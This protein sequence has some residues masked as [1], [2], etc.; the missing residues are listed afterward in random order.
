MGKS[1]KEVIHENH[2]K[3]NREYTERIRKY[4]KQQEKKNITIF[5]ILT[6]ILAILMVISIIIQKRDLDRC[7]AVYSTEYCELGL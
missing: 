6:A 4:K 3:A 7:K 1:M 2:I 5:C